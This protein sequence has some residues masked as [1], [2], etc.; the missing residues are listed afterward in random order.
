MHLISSGKLEYPAY[1]DKEAVDLI[2]H[3]LKVDE[4]E[5]IG[6]R[7]DAEVCRKE[8]ERGGREEGREGRK[9]GR[10]GREEGDT[11]VVGEKRIK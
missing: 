6:S 2:Q 9:E 4:K 1:F 3:L 5:R 7:G 8:E 11:E 10:E